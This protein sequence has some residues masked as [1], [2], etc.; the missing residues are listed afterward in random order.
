SPNPLL[1]LNPRRL[2]SPE[3]PSKPLIPGTFK[4]KWNYTGPTRD[5]LK[6][7]DLRQLSGDAQD[8]YNRELRAAAAC[9]R[10]RGNIYGG[11]GDGT[12]SDVTC[13]ASNQMQMQQAQQQRDQMDRRPELVVERPSRWHMSPADAEPMLSAVWTLADQL[14]PV[15]SGRLIGRAARTDR[16]VCNGGQWYYEATVTIGNTPAG[17]QPVPARVG[18]STSCAVCA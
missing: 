2:K 10:D 5:Q 3:K 7:S 8:A 18:W 13:G 9:Q 14:A 11:A 17:D 1:W 4:N 6:R 15:P 12:I 16:G